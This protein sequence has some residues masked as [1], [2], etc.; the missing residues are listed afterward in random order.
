MKKA[1]PR[2]LTKAERNALHLRISQERAAPSTAKR[3]A[4]L[5]ALMNL[6]ARVFS[7]GTSIRDEP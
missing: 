3:E 5:R 2:K 1:K 6:P 4:R 7:D